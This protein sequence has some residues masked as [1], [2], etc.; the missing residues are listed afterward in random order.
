MSD[1]K[2]P[3][4]QPLHSS[5]ATSEA[6]EFSRFTEILRRLRAPNGGCPWDIEQTF[7]SLAPQIIEEAYEVAEA[8]KEGASSL[9]EELGD[10]LSVIGLYAQIGEDSKSFS[11]IDVLRAINEKLIRRHPH[12]FGEMSVTGTEEVLK[13][14][15]AI[16][17]EEKAQKVGAKKD[18]L[19]SGI[20]RSMPALLKAHRIGEKCSRIN[21]DWPNPEGVVEK[22]KEELG[23]FIECLEKPELR[24]HLSEEFGDLLFSLAQLSRHLGINAEEALQSGNQKFQRRFAALEDLAAQHY[25]EAPL[26]ERSAQELN[27]L[28]NTV[29]QQ[30]RP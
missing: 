7:V 23:E 2:A 27:T 12:V 13:N 26:K 17:Q 8:A 6:E 29:K 3:F 10:L 19:L 30:E 18:G 5:H 20:P 1:T 4:S 22:V 21:F 15:E 9:P 24:E 25:P 28:W 14:W 16:K 11:H